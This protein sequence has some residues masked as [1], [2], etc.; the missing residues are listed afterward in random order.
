LYK[1]QFNRVQWFFRCKTFNNWGILVMSNKYKPFWSEMLNKEELMKLDPRALEKIG[2]K[3]GIELD[4][5]F[6]KINLVDQLYKVL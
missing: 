5:R 1:Q 4:R 2:R 6:S 3:H